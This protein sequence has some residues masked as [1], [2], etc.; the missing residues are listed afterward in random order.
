M[1]RRR[2]RLPREFYARE[3]LTVAQELIG[4]HLVHHTQHEL[5]R[6]RIVEVEAYI[7]EEDK[8]C[9]ARFGPTKRAAGLWGTPGTA[10]V[11]L[12]YGMYDCFNVVCEPEGSPAAVLIRALEPDPPLEAA[13]DGPG[14]LCRALAIT[15]AHNKADLVRG[16]PLWLEPREPGRAPPRLEATAR[17]G[18][19]YAEEWAAKPW[20]FVDADSEWLSRPLPG[21]KRRARRS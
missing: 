12:I 8:A 11:Y 19:D 5:L 13:T 15:R 20:R 7:H 9:H 6:G 21:G 10:Y 16:S 14:K 4:C 18:I 2:A 3:C 17:I 1:K